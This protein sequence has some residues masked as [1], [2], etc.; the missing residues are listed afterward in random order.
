MHLYYANTIFFVNRRESPPVKDCKVGSGIYEVLNGMCQT[1]QSGFAFSSGGPA[2]SLYPSQPGNQY[3]SCGRIHGPLRDL[4]LVGSEKIERPFLDN[5]P[6]PVRPS[7]GKLV[8]DQR[9]AAAK[10]EHIIHQSGGPAMR[11]ALGVDW[12]NLYK[13]ESEE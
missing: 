6:V 5:L 9:L 2:K 11:L 3:R 1:A 7:V 8:R 12:T 4:P 13:A 10:G